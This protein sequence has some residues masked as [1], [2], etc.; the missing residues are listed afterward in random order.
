MISAWDADKLL[1]EK[2][3]LN[4]WILIRLCF[5]AGNSP[6]NTI[7]LNFHVPVD[8]FKINT[9]NMIASADR[10]GNFEYLEIYQTIDTKRKDQKPLS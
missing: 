4:P 7:L 3:N 2:H 8:E 1:A 6:S 9:W 5:S 10:L